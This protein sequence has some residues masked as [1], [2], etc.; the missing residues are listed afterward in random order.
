MINYDHK[1]FKKEHKDHQYSFIE[2][3]VCVILLGVGFF[4]GIFL[5]HMIW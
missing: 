3:V 1:T 2:D 4:A 5:L